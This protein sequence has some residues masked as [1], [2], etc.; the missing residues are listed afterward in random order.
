MNTSGLVAWF[1]RR[2]IYYGWVIVAVMFVTLFISLGFRFAFGVFYSA[3]LDETGWLRAETAGIVSASMIVYACTAAL[4]GYLFDRLGA[5]VVFPVGALCMGAGLMLCS[6]SESL[7]GLT[8]SYGILLGFSYAALGFIPHMAIVPRWFARRRGL[9]SAASLAGV[10]LGSLGVA[11]L[12]AELIQYVGWRETMWWFGIAAMVVLIPLNILFH[13]HSAEHI[14]LT[15]DGPSAQPAARSAPARTG[16]TVGDAVRTPAFWLLALAVSMTGLCN[17]TIVVHQTRM[18]VDI[19]YSLPLAS[20]IFGMMGVTRAV[21]GLIWGPLSDRIGRS[22]CVVIICSI[23]LVG[24]TLLWLTSLLPAESSA[25]RMALLAGYLLT[26]GMGFSAMAPVYA[27]AVS[28]KFAGRNLGTILG[29]LDLGFG[30][31]SALG[32][33]WAG[34]MFDRYG[35]YDAVILGVAL[36]VVLTGVGLATA[37]RRGD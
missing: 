35:S 6:T 19:G 28:D 27:S 23:S 17:M 32:P 10:G 25:L 31:G 37:T 3:I 20:V 5:R 8:V 2:G 11:A 36:G 26:F 1:G 4:S 22:A 33:W 29:V 34:W 15:P 12:S 30:L 24:L 9:A 7:A 21:G 14:G 18:L 13:R 16:A